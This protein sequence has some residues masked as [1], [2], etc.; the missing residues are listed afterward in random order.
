MISHSILISC[1]QRI[2]HQDYWQTNILPSGKDS[3]CFSCSRNGRFTAVKTTRHQTI[4][5]RLP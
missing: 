3:A 4:T 5:R 2:L 1:L